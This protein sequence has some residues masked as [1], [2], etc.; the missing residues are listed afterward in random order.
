MRARTQTP[1]MEPVEEITIP[2]WRDD[3]QVTKLMAQAKTLAEQIEQLTAAIAQGQAQ[4]P[5]VH[6]HFMRTEALHLT[7]A[8]EAFEVDSARTREAQLA[9][10]VTTWEE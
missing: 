9:A 8:V 4:L 5:A 2:H 6:E 3:A 10:D 7:G 1:V